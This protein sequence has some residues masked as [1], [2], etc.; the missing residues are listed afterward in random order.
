[1]YSE[2]ELFGGGFMVVCIVTRHSGT[3]D[4]VL[5]KL[6]GRGVGEDVRVVGHLSEKMILRMRKGD[7]VYGILPIHLIKRLLRKGV[8]YYHVVLPHVPRELRGTELSLDQ[9]KEFGGQIWKIEDIKS[10]K[11]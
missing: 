8:E 3:V 6:K 10:F 9:V 5:A 4:W 1:M 7:V 2:D 11:L